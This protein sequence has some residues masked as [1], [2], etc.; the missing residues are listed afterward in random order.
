MRHA[1]RISSWKQ[2]DSNTRPG[3]RPQEPA[4]SRFP[5]FALVPRRDRVRLFAIARTRGDDAKK[6][7][8]VAGVGGKPNPER[9]FNDQSIDT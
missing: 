2:V 6:E 3:Q 5:V 9:R 8:S 4:T 1:R 7:S